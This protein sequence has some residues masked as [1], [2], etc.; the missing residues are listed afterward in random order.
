MA[1]ATATA[2][3]AGPSNAPVAQVSAA[4]V[5]KRLHPRSYLAQYLDSG[6]RPDGRKVGEWRDVSV[7]PGASC[8][9]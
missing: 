1:I 3:E 9:S 6:Y 7:V 8:S 2:A 4:Q 5:F